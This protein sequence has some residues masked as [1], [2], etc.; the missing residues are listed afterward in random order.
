MNLSPVSGGGVQCALTPLF[1][2]YYTLSCDFVGVCQLGETI[3]NFHSPQAA[4]RREI[5]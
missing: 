2:V 5:P 1:D 4:P 3:M